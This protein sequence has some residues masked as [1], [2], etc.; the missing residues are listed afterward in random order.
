M[1]D[2]LDR[3]YTK[4]SVAR[5]CIDNLLG[6]CEEGDLFVEPSAGGGAFFRQLPENKIGVDL[7]PAV[8]GVV[9]HD[10]LTYPVPQDCVIVGNPP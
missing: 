7:S 2:D 5:S 1:K 9:E 8:D 3:F 4:D 6:F 10:W